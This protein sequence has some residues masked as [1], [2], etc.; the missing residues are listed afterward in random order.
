MDNL[1]AEAFLRISEY[2]DFD[3]GEEV[4]QGSV[5]DEKKVSQ[6]LELVEKILAASL[7]FEPTFL[8]R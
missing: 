6:E 3:L 2:F 4:L 7:R 1:P 8:E 5:N